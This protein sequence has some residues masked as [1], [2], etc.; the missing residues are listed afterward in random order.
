MPRYTLTGHCHE[1]L[2]HT[3]FVVESESRL[4]RLRKDAKIAVLGHPN[5]RQILIFTLV[6]EY[7]SLGIN[8]LAYCASHSCVF[9]TSILRLCSSF[10]TIAR[11]PYEKSTHIYPEPARIYE[12][13]Y[14]RYGTTAL[15]VIQAKALQPCKYS[16]KQGGS[17]S[18]AKTSVH[19]S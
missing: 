11:S 12:Y 3:F 16:S 5:K 17:R 8:S 2:D 15:S 9:T 7:N 18:A 14:R 1:Y 13:G 19:C 10:K 4:G 6:I